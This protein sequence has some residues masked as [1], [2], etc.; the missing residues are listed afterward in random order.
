MKDM[1]AAAEEH[2]DTSRCPSDICTDR[3]Y[4]SENI[5]L[6]ATVTGFLLP[7]VSA[8]RFKNAD[9][10]LARNASSDAGDAW[11]HD[12]CSLRGPAI[13]WLFLRV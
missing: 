11:S 3:I 2:S 10:S 5:I 8:L 1:M 7:R 6:S 13:V 4:L 9:R 12:D